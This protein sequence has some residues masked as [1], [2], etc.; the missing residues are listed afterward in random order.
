MPTVATKLKSTKDCAPST[1]KSGP[2]A[3]T[4]RGARTNLDAPIAFRP[5]PTPP[6]ASA[7]SA[8][9]GSS[10]HVSFT[11]MEHTPTGPPSPVRAH[12]PDAACANPALH[13][14]VPVFM[15]TP[16]S[17]DIAGSSLHV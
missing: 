1:S 3:K 16:A 2:R 9:A 11:P 5:T 10:R 4:K 8:Y 6:V 14:Q 15:Q 17:E 13:S 12:L 7:A